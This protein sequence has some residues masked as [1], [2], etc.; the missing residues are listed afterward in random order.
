MQKHISLQ[1]VDLDKGTVIYRSRQ[2]S[3]DTN[4]GD[5]LVVEPILVGLCRSDIKEAMGVR[6]VRHDFGHEIIGKITDCSATSGFTI[7]EHV[8]YDPHIELDRSSGFSTSIVVFAKQHQLQKAFLKINNNTDPRAAVFIEPLSCTMHC[9]QNLINQIPDKKLQNLTIAIV[10][11]GN[12]GTLLGLLLEEFGARV[13]L[14]NRSKNRLKYL[15]EKQIFRPDQLLQ[16]T[17]KPVIKDSYDVVIPMTSFLF[18]DV[19]SFS[20]KIVKKSGILV[21]Y[22]GTKTGDI[23]PKTSIEIDEIRRNELVK[24]ITLSSKS[25]TLLGTHGAITADFV[26]TIKFLNNISLSKKLINLIDELVTL[27]KL[28]EKF[29]EIINGKKINKIVVKVTYE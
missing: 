11:A 7:G 3:W 8:V 26:D 27:E 15:I 13:F 14:Y 5:Y 25:I 17:K 2:I 21:L 23:F 24:K 29:A 10:G 22:G 12:A 18:P 20:E 6:T 16:I 19:L 28:P 4:D 1:E 9:L